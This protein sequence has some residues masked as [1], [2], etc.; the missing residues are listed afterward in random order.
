[1]AFEHKTTTQEN[2]FHMIGKTKWFESLKEK[3][4]ISPII[5]LWVFY[6]FVVATALE[7]LWVAWPKLSFGYF[8]VVW[9]ADVFYYIRIFGGPVVAGVI[10]YQVG[11]LTKNNI[12]G[13]AT[14]AVIIIGWFIFF[15]NIVA[16]IPKV[17]HVYKLFVKHRGDAEPNDWY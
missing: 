13:W 9:A 1:M 12:V 5:F 3:H 14:F 15:D 10:A 11:I 16:E 6:G 8:L 2:G 17:G 4:G 7:S